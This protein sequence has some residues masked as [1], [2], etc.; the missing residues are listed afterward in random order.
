MR[1]PLR[2]VALVLSAVGLAAVIP[3]STLRAQTA[4]DA[5]RSA[6]PDRLPVGRSSFVGRVTSPAGLPVDGAEVRVLSAP[7]PLRF[8]VPG[9]V[10]TDSTGAYTLAGFPAGSY[11]LEAR[12]LGF[13]PVN[14]SAT[15]GAAERRRTDL[16][17]DPLPQQLRAV[18]V[19]ARSGYTALATIRDRDIARRRAF[20]VGLFLTR[21][22]IRQRFGGATS[23]GQVLGMTKMEVG[24][25]RFIS[26]VA[27]SGLATIE[28][29]AGCR[30][31]SLIDGYAISPNPDFG[32]L[33][34]DDVEALE[35]YAS[36]RL[37]PSL[38]IALPAA[39]G[40]ESSGFGA[41]QG[42]VLPPNNQPTLDGLTVIVWTGHRAN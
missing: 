29:D 34:L 12:R 5:E 22:Q 30:V 26:P 4:P 1:A 35:I 10:R 9:A 8:E 2:V 23:V 38:Q 40:T 13:A 20:A 36:R 31:Q 41:A 17:L 27:T 21:E 7:R 24:G 25:C 32:D 37:P 28:R 33:R 15:I 16:V 3:V 42:L 39:A 14:F 18:Q 11:L 6:E 19:E